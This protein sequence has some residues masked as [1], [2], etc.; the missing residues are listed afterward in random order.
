M[1]CWELLTEKH[2]YNVLMSPEEVM[3]ALN[4]DAQLPSEKPTTGM[5]IFMAATLA[6]PA[7]QVA[8]V[9]TGQLIISLQ[10]E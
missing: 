4:G 7:I 5:A 6:A 2:F 1:V 10:M 3:E 8:R 9:V